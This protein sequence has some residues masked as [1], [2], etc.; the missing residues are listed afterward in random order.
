MAEKEKANSEKRKAKA[1]GKDLPISTKHAVAICAAIRNKKL[2]EAQHYL[3]E[4]VAKKKLVPM[5]GEI[6]H[7][8]G[9]PGRYPVKAALCF[10]KLLK[11]LAANAATKGIDVENAII[12]KAAAHKAS[13]PY[14]ATRLAYGR[15]RFKRTNV[16]LEAGI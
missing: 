3:E 16:E 15:K 10:S 12:T 11:Q 2:R 1:L 8:V 4:V 6:P 14:R 7:H 5:K 9:K 13:R